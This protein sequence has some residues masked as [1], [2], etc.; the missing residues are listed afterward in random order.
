MNFGAL[1]IATLWRLAKDDVVRQAIV[2]D[3]EHGPRL[4]IV[5]TDRIVQWERFPTAGPLRKRAVQLR[6]EYRKKGWTPVDAP[7]PDLRKL[8]TEMR[9]F[10]V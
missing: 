2:I 8:K 3:G 7:T 4:V 10:E 1:H 6:T 9:R 5:E